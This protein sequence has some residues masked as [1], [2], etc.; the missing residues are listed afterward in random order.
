MKEIHQFLDRI[1]SEGEDFLKNFS[2]VT[3]IGEGLHSL[4][5]FSFL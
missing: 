5:C 1:R 4:F 3:L 2:F